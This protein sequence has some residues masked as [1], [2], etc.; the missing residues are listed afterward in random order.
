MF[1]PPL[2]RRLELADLMRLPWVAEATRRSC[3]PPASTASLR[4]GFEAAAGMELPLILFQTPLTGDERSANRG[5][6]GRVIA[7][8]FRSDPAAR[9]D[10]PSPQAMVARTPMSAV[11]KAVIAL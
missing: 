10:L 9:A 3:S 5:K 6:A 7:Y 8:V 2:E 4:P 11:F 1:V